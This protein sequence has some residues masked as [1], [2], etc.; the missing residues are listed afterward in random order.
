MNLRKISLKYMG[1]CPGVESA[2]RFVPDR[3]INGWAMAVAGM[4]L[5]LFVVMHM[6]YELYLII[7]S[8]LLFG[9]AA[10]SI[11]VPLRQVAH[12][13][14]SEDV[15]GTYTYEEYK[16]K[17]R[18]YLWYISGRT[19]HPLWIDHALNADY[20]RNPKWQNPTILSYYSGRDL[21]EVPDW[22]L[23]QIG[24]MEPIWWVFVVLISGFVFFGLIWGLMNRAGG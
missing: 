15:D 18:P 20:R 12:K 2:A 17:A 9:L 21:R 10:F 24:F 23:G 8:L 22:K 19:P 7:V 14:E 16:N 13:K 1:W 6:T 11:R 5:L 4:A 3:E